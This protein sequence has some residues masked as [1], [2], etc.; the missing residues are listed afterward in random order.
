M[1]EDNYR[2]RETRDKISRSRYSSRCRTS[3]NI[4]S[5]QEDNYGVRKTR[6]NIS[7]SRCN[8]RCRTNIKTHPSWTTSSTNNI[9]I[10]KTSHAASTSSRP[11]NSKDMTSCKV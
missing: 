7:G 8:S 3:I 2:V 11:G 4:K 9:D 5:S 10:D 1:K 6:D